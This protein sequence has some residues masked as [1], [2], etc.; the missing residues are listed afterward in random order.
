MHRLFSGVV[1][2]G[3]E[4]NSSSSHSLVLDPKA[5]PVLT[6]ASD[7]GVVADDG[8]LVIYG[9]K[10]FGWEWT[11]WDAPDDK[12][13]YL[14]ADGFDLDRMVS[15]LERYLGMKV[16]FAPKDEYDYGIDHQSE[17]RSAEIQALSDERV[18]AFLTNPKN[19]I[20]GGNDNEEGPW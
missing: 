9:T 2:A 11:I 1:R 8:V 5:G 14:L 18:W 19:Q 17:G 20:R 10:S 4:T 13:Q 3:W 16:R 6:Q 12:V 7:F 15:L